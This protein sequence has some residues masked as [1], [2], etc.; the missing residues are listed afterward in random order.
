MDDPFPCKEPER[1]KWQTLYAPKAAL[2]GAED[3][4][5]ELVQ[6]YSAHRHGILPKQV[7]EL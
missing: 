2:K 4:S 3:S 1:E 5:R 7:Q 6:E